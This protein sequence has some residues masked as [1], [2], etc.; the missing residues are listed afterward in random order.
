MDRPTDRFWQSIVT[1]FVRNCLHLVDENWGRI[2][3]LVRCYHNSSFLHCLVMF[4]VDL[5][6]EDSSHFFPKENYRKAM[7]R[8][9]DLVLLM[10]GRCRRPFVCCMC[11]NGPM[12][13]AGAQTVSS[14]LDMICHEGCSKTDFQNGHGC[15]SLIGCLAT[16]DVNFLDF[17]HLFMSAFYM[18]VVLCCQV[19]SGF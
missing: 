12:A 10:D 2:Y 8:K 1:A 15:L 5:F 6:R 13:S 19:W 11:C 9:S 14:G 17:H 4:L 3:C 7:T 18:T 16:C